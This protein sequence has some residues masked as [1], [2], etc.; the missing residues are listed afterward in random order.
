MR[1]YILWEKK[2]EAKDKKTEFFETQEEFRAIIELAEKVRLKKE[3]IKATDARR[4]EVKAAVEA[5]LKAQDEEKADKKAQEEEDNRK[6]Q[7]IEVS[8]EEEDNSD[9]DDFVMIDVEQATAAAL[10]ELDLA[11][12]EDADGYLNFGF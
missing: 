1:I 6:A 5:A 2:L 7:A 3:A 9:D 10:V 8:R 4:L 11:G 12:K